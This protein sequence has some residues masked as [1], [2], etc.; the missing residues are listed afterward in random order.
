MRELALILFLLPLYAPAQTFTL[1][2]VGTDSFYV[3]PLDTMRYAL[4]LRQTADTTIILDR[5]QI[6]EIASAAV[7]L[8]GAIGE[9]KK[10]EEAARVESENLRKEGERLSGLLWTCEEK[11]RKMKPWAIAGKIGT[12]AVGLTTLWVVYKALKP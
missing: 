9:A 8:H 7:N 1:L 11:R 2:V 10:M 4:S 5:A 6:R 12:V 3:A